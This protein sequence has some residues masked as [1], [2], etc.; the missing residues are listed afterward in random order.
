MSDVPSTLKITLKHRIW[1]ITIDD[2]F[3]GDYRSQRHATESAEA[4]AAKMRT[5]GRRVTILAADAQA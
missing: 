1:R 4:A 2:V 3:Y 5:E